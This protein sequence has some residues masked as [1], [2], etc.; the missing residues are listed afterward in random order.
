MKK[1]LN[2]KYL[3]ICLY[4]FGLVAAILIFN[5]ILNSLGDLLQAVSGWAAAIWSAVSALVWGALIAYIFYPLTHW[6][7]RRLLG[8]IKKWPKLR[9][10]LSI[11][12]IYLSFLAVIV[13]GIAYLVPEIIVNL[14]EL[15]NRV[16]DYVSTVEKFL[17]ENV[18]AS[19]WWNSADV[20]NWLDT[21]IKTLVANLESILQTALPSVFGYVARTISGMFTAILALMVSFFIL[22]DRDNLGN[23]FNRLIR[24]NI[25]TFYSYFIKCFFIKWNY[26]WS[27]MRNC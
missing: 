4:A 19:D 3:E 24:I 1:R 17:N 21:Q 25:P 9:R 11:A 23:S 2:Q 8:W 26:Y 18:W 27:I 13:W 7:E 12:L 6:V 20:Q 14:K 10:M 22:M 16:P 15:W 5:E